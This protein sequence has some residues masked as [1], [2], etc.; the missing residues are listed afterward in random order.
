[1]PPSTILQLARLIHE[2]VVA[3]EQT[4]LQAHTSVPDLDVFEF[5]HSSEAFR[6]MPVAAEMAKIAVSACMQLSAIL[7]PPTDTVYRL[8]L[9]VQC[10]NNEDYQKIPL[11]KDNFPGSSLFCNA[12]MFGGKCH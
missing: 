9:G 12:H 11:I 6:D 7:L 4:C 1:M 8:A 10:R 3:L 2:S 5:D